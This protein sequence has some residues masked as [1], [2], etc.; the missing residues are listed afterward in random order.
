MTIQELNN[1]TKLAKEINIKTINELTYFTKFYCK[2]NEPL[3][4]AITRYKNEKITDNFLSMLIFE[5]R[6]IFNQMYQKIYGFNGQPTL[7]KIKD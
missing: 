4:K 5:E 3:E 1:I 6:K 7:I 2:E